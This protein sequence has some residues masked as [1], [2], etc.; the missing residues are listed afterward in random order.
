MVCAAPS[1]PRASQDPRAS[2]VRRALKAHRERSALGGKS[3]NKVQ[4]DLEEN[5]VLK[6]RLVPQGLR[7]QWVL[8]GRQVPRGPQVPKVL[9]APGGQRVPRVQRDRGEPPDRP[10]LPVE[11]QGGPLQG[12]AITMPTNRAV[13]MPTHPRPVRRTVVVIVPTRTTP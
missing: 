8:E 6:V 12:V 10:V 9:R 2:P 3:V 7:G 13:V 4:R 1:V 11:P 5:Q